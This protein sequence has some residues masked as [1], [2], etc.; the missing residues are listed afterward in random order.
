MADKLFPTDY[1]EVTSTEA[2]DFTPV[3]RQWDDLYKIKTDSL[4]STVAGPEGNWIASITTNKVAK[5]TTVTITEDDSTVTTFDVED[6]ADGAGS[7]D[8]LASWTLT[9]DKIILGDGTKTVKTSSK[10]I[11]TT[12]GTDDTSIPT[13]KAVKDVT[14]T[15]LPLAWGT[16][17][18]KV[19]GAGRTEVAKTYTPATGSQTVALDCSVNNMH[20]VTGHASG[21]AITFTITGATS[22]QPFIVSI[23][24]GWTTVSTIAAWFATV[25]WAW[26]TAPTLTAT[27]NKRDTF[28]FIRTWTDAYDWFVIGQ[29]C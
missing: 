21:T 13:S 8:V 28:W 4:K 15:K 24:Q 3:Y 22:N 25:R 18:G 26:G 12:L 5:T 10:G 19:V 1:T 9:A 17:T 27:L 16:M 20:V 23:L 7:G 11:V 29:N 14:D 6:W 2:T